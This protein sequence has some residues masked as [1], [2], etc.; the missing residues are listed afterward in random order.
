MPGYNQKPLCG[1]YNR[2]TQYQYFIIDLKSITNYSL[3]LLINA[4]VNFNY[5]K[6]GLSISILYQFVK[7]FP[8]Q[9]QYQFILSMFPY[10][11]DTLRLPI[12]IN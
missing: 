10:D 9:F 3:S 4:N 5:L 1:L 6:E 12:S 7:K 2:G 8:Y 11:I